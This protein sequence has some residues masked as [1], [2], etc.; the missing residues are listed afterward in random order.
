[1][2]LLPEHDVILYVLKSEMVPCD[3]TVR[4]S[5]DYRVLLVIPLEGMT[6]CA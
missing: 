1:M 5:P 2:N 6:I 3:T 4:A